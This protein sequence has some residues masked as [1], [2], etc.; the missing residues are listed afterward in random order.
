MKA[1]VIAPCAGIA[2]FKVGNVS[3]VESY[4]DK[5]CLDAEVFEKDGVF[6]A[7]EDNSFKIVVPTANLVVL[8]DEACEEETSG[9]SP[10]IC[11]GSSW[12]DV[13]AAVAEQKPKTLLSAMKEADASAFDSAKRA[14]FDAL[15][16]H[17]GNKVVAMRKVSTNWMRGKE[18]IQKAAEN[19]DFAIGD[20]YH[21]DC[22]AIIAN[23]R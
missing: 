8:F 23:A 13:L 20:E 7:V 4:L 21:V 15:C 5:Y 19:P 2:P 17:L 1:I 18:R 9:E 6:L 3:D 10:L 12:N 22:M 11:L 16:E 14:K